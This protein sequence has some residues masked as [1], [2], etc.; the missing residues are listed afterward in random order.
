[1]MFESD[2]R[3]AGIA[4]SAYLLRLYAPDEPVAVTPV[5]AS[6]VSMRALEL[7]D[8]RLVIGAACTAVDAAGTV[9]RACVAIGENHARVHAIEVA[10]PY[11]EGDLAR[12][13]A[14]VIGVLE[15]TPLPAERCT[16]S[17]V[18]PG[19][20][21]L[22]RTLLQGK[23]GVTE[24]ARYHALHPETAARVGLARLANFVLERMP[25]T[26]D[27]YCFWG[28]SH[29]VPQDERLFVLVDV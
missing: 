12:V 25:G 27:I 2:L 16:L 18:Q 7:A 11:D 9:E 4:L 8:G 22:H 28:R 23:D 26:D 29:A 19:G 15:T 5:R 21:D 10:V 1:W 20:G 6:G 24:D 17:F 14:A 13:V 3:R